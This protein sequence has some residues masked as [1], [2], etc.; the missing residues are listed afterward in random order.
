MTTRQ[1]SQDVP[2]APSKFQKI[3]DQENS[4]LL[5]VHTTAI[6][7]LVSS[8]C[9]YFYFFV[10][11]RPYY[12][13]LIRTPFFFVFLPFFVCLFDVLFSAF[14]AILK[15]NTKN[16]G[17][18]CIFGDFKFAPFFTCFFFNFQFCSKRPSMKFFIKK[19]RGVY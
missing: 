7:L 3:R 14:F 4:L 13:G 17:M 15:L 1:F 11:E 12:K 6:I 19:A 16:K 2:G 10:T 18:G 9:F 5:Y 8:S